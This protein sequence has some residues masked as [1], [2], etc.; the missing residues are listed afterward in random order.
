MK[1]VLN[2]SLPVILELTLY[3]FLSVF[4]MMIIGKCGGSSE[5]SQIGICNNI[6]NTCLNI[7]IFTGICI[8]ITTLASQ[9]YG[10]VRYREANEYAETGF[11]IGIVISVL[12]GVFMYMNANKILIIAGIRRENLIHTAKVMRIL[13]ISIVF[14]MNINVINSI[15]RS[16]KNM[17]QPFKIS[18][19]VS[20]SKIALDFLFI[21]AFREHISAAYGA[22]IAS[23]LSQLIGFILD[24]YYIVKKSTDIKINVFIKININKIVKLL[25]LSIPSSFE[26]AAYSL[27]RLICTF[28][29]MRSGNVAFAANEIANSIESVSFMPGTGFGMV[30]TTLV[31][32]NYGRRDLKGIKKSA[33]EC[34][35]Y[36]LI[37]MMSLAII[38]LFGSEFLVGFFINETVTM[39]YAAV[40]LA[41]GAFEQPTIALSMVFSNALKGMGDTKTPFIITTIS[42]CLI[43][44][45]LTYVYIHILNKPIYYVWWITVIEWG[46]DGVMMWLLFNLKVRKLKSEGKY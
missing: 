38:F 4:D 43:R 1:K 22:A 17:M 20:V 30:A 24:Y 45:P 11:F 2:I 9:S 6:F 28:I 37:L 34:F 31:G 7:F 44:L 5:V 42:S 40:C 39:K 35:Y 15:L 27:S 36:S 13:C 26:E 3:N 16:Y 33:N 10:A 18:I 19:Y 32:I 25:K 21:F 29:I 8:G 12:V 46:F 14:N 41:I 23:V